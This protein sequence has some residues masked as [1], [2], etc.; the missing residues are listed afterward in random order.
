MATQLTNLV[1]DQ[2][3]L[4]DDGANP[5]ARVMLCK[6]KETPMADTKQD[7]PGIAPEVAELAKRASEAE[8]QVAE[9]TKRLADSDAVVKANAEEVAKMRETA[10]RNAAI[11]IAKGLG[12]VAPADDLASIIQ[13]V[14]RT[15]PETGEKLVAILAAAEAKIKS[16]ALFSEVGK[17]GV[18]EKSSDPVAEMDRL[19]TAYA[20][21]HKVSVAKAHAVLG[22]SDPAY[23]AAYTKDYFKGGR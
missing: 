3:D 8:R 18:V 23:R 6:R 14:R 10:D 7:T 19:A 20:G 11:E 22:K 1:I 5:G 17:N 16:G 15:D 21:E 12:N 9:L 2:I 13:K 4:V